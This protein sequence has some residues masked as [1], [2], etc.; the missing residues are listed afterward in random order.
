MINECDVRELKQKLDAKENIQFIDVR[1]QA[2]WDEA[3]IAGATLLPLSKLEAIYEN[4]LKDKDAQI[5]IHCR[6][7]ARSMNACMFLM[8]K[9]FTNLTNVKGGIMGWAQEG[10]PIITK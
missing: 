8:S 10:F 1:E 4:F 9:G 5:V 3:H 2:E 6:S 7:G